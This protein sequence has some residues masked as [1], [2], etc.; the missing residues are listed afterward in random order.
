MYEKNIRDRDGFLV[1]SMTRKWREVEEFHGHLVCA[2]LYSFRKDSIVRDGPNMVDISSLGINAVSTYRPTGAISPSANS[3]IS[4][5][6]LK[7]DRCSTSGTK[8]RTDQI[9][10]ESS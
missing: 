3:Q 8:A 9:P 2:I 1:Y 10:D 4:E 5:N 6:A 7:K